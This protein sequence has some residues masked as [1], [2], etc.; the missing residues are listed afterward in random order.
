MAES[1]GTLLAKSMQKHAG[2]A[3]EKVKST[4]DPPPAVA[5]RTSESAVLESAMR[6]ETVCEHSWRHD[7]IATKKKKIATKIAR[8]R[9]DGASPG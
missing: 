4:A 9:M 6:S 1:K 5:P 7:V 2:R 3:K 8:H